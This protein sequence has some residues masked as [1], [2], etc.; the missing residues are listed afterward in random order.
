MPVPSDCQP[1]ADQVAALEQ[2]YSALSAQASG[3]TG[4]PAWAALGQLGA[5]HEQLLGARTALAQCVA[6]H[7]AALTGT[8]ALIDAPAGAA[9]EQ[10]T[11]TLWELGAAGPVA[12]ELA[13]VTAGAFGFQGPL[14]AQAAITLQ[15]AVTAGN[16]ITGVDFRSGALP[17]P[18]AGQTPRVELVVAPQVTVSAEHVQTWQS[19]AMPIVQQVIIAPLQGVLD[20]NI[21]SL[22]IALGDGALA[23]TATGSVS[24]GLLAGLLKLAPTP[25]LVSGGLAVLASGSPQADEIV[26]VGVMPANPISL[27]VS[28][29]LQPVLQAMTFAQPYVE[30]LLRDSL[31]AGANAALGP[32][33]ASSLALADLPAGASL[34]LRTLTVDQ[35]GITLQPVI[36]AIG[37]TL[38]TFKPSPL[39]L[40]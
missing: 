26:H 27:S 23:L 11:V 10:Q 4:A 33:I 19:A 28:S 37:Q 20:I 5:I 2:Q 18:L 1:L 31:H 40:P 30:Q 34:S 16:A 25:L 6:T 14:P 22:D 17:G 3:A 32:A 7:S 21:S 8:I 9:T 38:S 35:T 39:P 29:A 12:R 24:G 36:G 13:E 15:T